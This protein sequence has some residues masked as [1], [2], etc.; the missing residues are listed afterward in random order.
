[1]KESL[2]HE[3]YP[4]YT[5]EVD[6][7][8]CSCNS[9]EEIVE[10]LKKSIELHDRASY[11]DMFDHLKPDCSA[12]HP[13]VDEDIVHAKSILFCFALA[14]PSPKT[15]ATNPRS[16]GIV[17]L[18]DGFVITFL[19]TPMPLANTTMEKWARLALT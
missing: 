9:I 11:I 2:S 4:L 12:S 17:E 5:I 14:L 13:A 15:T 6:K 7:P 8:A 19:E 3:T 1:M 18:K 10:R 16:M